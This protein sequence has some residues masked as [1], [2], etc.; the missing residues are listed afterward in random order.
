MREVHKFG[1]VCEQDFV[2]M[3]R[4]GRRE[5]RERELREERMREFDNFGIDCY[6][7]R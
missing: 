5:H 7:G 3:N 1:I 2:L 6:T 4:R